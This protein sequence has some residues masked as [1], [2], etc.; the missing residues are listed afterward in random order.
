MI[1]DTE[2]TK[3]AEYLLCAIYKAYKEGRKSGKSK[4]DAKMIGSSK[5]IHSTLM[6]EWSFEDVDETCRELS[7]ADYADCQYADNVTWHLALTDKA[8]IY[9]ENRFV[10]GLTGVLEYMAKIKQAILF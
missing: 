5:L 1:V 7:R 9:M 4:F 6:S 10:N 8:I 2:L 3:D